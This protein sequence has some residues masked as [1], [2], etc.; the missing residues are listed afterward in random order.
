MEHEEGLVISAGPKH[1]FIR[2]VGKPDRI[3]WL[4]DAPPGLKKL[5]SVRYQ[6]LPQPDKPHDRAVNIELIPVAA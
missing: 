5:R 2:P 6:V 3:F 1:G 4:S